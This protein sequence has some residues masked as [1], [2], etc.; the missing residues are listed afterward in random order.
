MARLP[1]GF[2]RQ[3]FWSEGVIIE[4]KILGNYLIIMDKDLL[5]T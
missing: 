2:A 4:I 1:A 5:L 3:L